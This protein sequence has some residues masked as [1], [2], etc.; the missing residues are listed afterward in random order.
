MYI[1]HTQMPKRLIDGEALWGSD[2][3]AR[4]A[5]QKYRAEYANLIPLALAN[6]VFEADPAKV[7]AKVYAFNRPKVRPKHVE[8]ILASFE[9]AGMLFRWQDEEGKR[10]GFW[11][12]INGRLPSK[13]RAEKLRLAVGPEPPKES[14]KAYLRSSNVAPTELLPIGMVREGCGEGMGREGKENPTAQAS[15]SLG[16]FETFWK[17]YPKKIG[18]AKS[19]RLWKRLRLSVEEVLAGIERWK[20]TQQ[21]KKE[22]GQFIPYPETFLRNERW[23]EYPPKTWSKADDRTRRNLEALGFV[24][25]PCEEVSTPV[26]GSLPPGGERQPS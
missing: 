17:A 10:W 14:L 9:Q 19:E 2:K 11:I 21:W 7:W 24:P 4:V 22:G 13:D 15:P 3:L 1:S 5:P 6:G 26:R 16:E 12:G 20:Q 23:K 25:P 8:E 18:K